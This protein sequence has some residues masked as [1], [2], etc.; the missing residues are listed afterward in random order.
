MNVHHIRDAR[1]KLHTKL[2]YHVRQDISERIYVCQR[3]L[4]TNAWPYAAVRWPLHADSSREKVGAPRHATS[5][6]SWV[7]L[8]GRRDQQSDICRRYL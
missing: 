7:S 2:M 3:M 4:V 5:C 8:L 6:G 1:T